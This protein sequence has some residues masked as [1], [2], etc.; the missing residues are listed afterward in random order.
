[1]PKTGPCSTGSIHRA[2]VIYN[3][4][5]KKYVMWFFHF[6]QYPDTM[7]AVATA[8]R[9]TG[10]F[11]ILGNRKSGEDN[12]LGQDLGASSYY[13]LPLRLD[14]ATGEA[15]LLYGGLSP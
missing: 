15:R 8:D 6:T 1:M 11:R 13:F 10:P 14:P 9:P 5:T 7:L 3:D 12:G 4:K 2:N